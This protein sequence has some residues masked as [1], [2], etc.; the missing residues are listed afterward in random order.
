MF[1]K[2]LLVSFLFPLSV[3]A[4]STSFSAIT[5]SEFEDISKEFAG[6][7]MH[8]SVQGAAPLGDVFGFEVGLVGGQQ[9]SP[10]IDALSKRAGGSGVSNLYHA[11]LLGVVS[12]PFGITGE[13]L[14]LPKLSANSAEA[15]MTSLGLKW[16]M[17]STL[18]VLPFN[19]ALRGFQTTSKFSF[20]QTI[21]PP[22]ATATVEDESTVTGFQLLASPSLPVVEP[23]VGIGTLS[24]K[25]KLGSSLGS[26]FADGSSSKEKNLSSTQLL[27]GVNAN[28]LFFRLGAEYSSAFGANSISAK[29]AFG[30]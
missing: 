4:Q 27:L 26:V 23:Y 13:L 25:N 5:D 19:L 18:V 15:S 20:N 28:L 16:S 12:V 11:G 17:N 29:L 2:I 24:A 21:T 30:F 6:N 9:P 14:V 7:F 22:G 10:K 3:F 1:K 8:H